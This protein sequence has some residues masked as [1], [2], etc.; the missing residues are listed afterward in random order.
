MVWM[1]AF[2]Y[3]LP[4]L[5][6]AHYQSREE[7]ERALVEGAPSPEIATSRSARFIC[8]GPDIELDRKRFEYDHRP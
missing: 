4:L 8:L 7:C 1:I 6:I 3:G 2:L 5:P